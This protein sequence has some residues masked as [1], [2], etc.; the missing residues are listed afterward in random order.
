MDK[1]EK[2]P[3]FFQKNGKD[4]AHFGLSYLYKLPYTHSVKDGLPPAHSDNRKDLAET[5]FGYIEQDEA[6]KGR[7]QFSHCKAVQ[8]AVELKKRTEILGTPRAS[9]YP[10]YVKQY[11][12]DFK[13]FM[14]G[15]FAISG[16][17]RYPVHQ[18]A[19]VVKTTDTGNE[20]VGTTFSPLK[21]GVVF[22][23]KLRFHNLRKSELGALLSALTFHNTQECFHNIGMAKSLG[24]G[25]IKLKLEGIENIG[26][27]D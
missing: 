10:I 14:H 25:K 18:G 23:G 20:N 4:V 3:V 19:G 6:L 22:S 16:W 15:D 11:S 17:K 27:L 21:D 1:G 2:V 24:Y 8:N 12:T 9:Y 7:V 13:T 26:I 5:M